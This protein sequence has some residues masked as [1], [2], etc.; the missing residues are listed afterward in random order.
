MSLVAGLSPGG[1][2]KLVKSASVC[3]QAPSRFLAYPVTSIRTFDIQFLP[4]NPNHFYT[5]TNLGCVLHNVRYGGKATPRVFRNKTDSVV[6][7]VTIDVSPFCGEF[8]LVCYMHLK[9]SFAVVFSFGIGW[10][11]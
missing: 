5:A 6:N 2:V 9:R 1:R 11:S 7:V 3:L 4:E 10:V 8:L